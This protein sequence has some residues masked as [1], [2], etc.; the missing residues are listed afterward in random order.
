MQLAEHGCLFRSFLNAFLI[1]ATQ[2]LKVP[3]AANWAPV[4]SS[5]WMWWCLCCHPHQYHRLKAQS[6]SCPRMAPMCGRCIRFSPRR[7]LST[8]MLPPQR[9]EGRRGWGLKTCCNANR[10]IVTGRRHEHQADWLFWSS[11]SKWRSILRSLTCAFKGLIKCTVVIFLK[12]SVVRLN[13][14]TPAG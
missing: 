13:S 7:F 2:P 4:S 5:D 14:E 10:V 6:V 1:L 9:G 8:D 11:Y 12:R 3:P